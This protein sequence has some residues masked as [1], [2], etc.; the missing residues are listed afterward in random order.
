MVTAV[1]LDID[2]D[3]SVEFGGSELTGT[4]KAEGT[5][6]EVRVSDLGVVLAGRR[7]DIRSLRAFALELARRGVVVSLAGPN[8]V[9]ASMGAVRAPAGDRL[10]TG[11]PHI[12]LRSLPAIIA[13]VR[14]KPTAP[15][16]VFPPPGTLLPLAPTLERQRRTRVTTTH[17][18]PGSGR[19]RLI[20][21]LGSE[22][23]NGQPPREF[24]LTADVTTIGSHESADLRLAGLEPFHAEIRHDADDE[25]VLVFGTDVPGS[26]PVLDPD[27]PR[28]RI[29]RTGARIELGQWRMGFFRAEFADHGRPF[30]GRMGG[31]FAYQKPQPPRPGDGRR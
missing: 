23:W 27:A 2:L 21:V 16:P 9:V 3:F 17:Y 25:Y 28:R 12:R 4:V 1:R 7:R 6:V 15:S 10:L 19:P 30:G 24:D 8:G 26:R 20:F 31:E 14:A 18:L 11:S 5:E 22:T 29:L 13:A